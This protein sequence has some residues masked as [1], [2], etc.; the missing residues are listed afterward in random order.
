MLKPSPILLSDIFPHSP[1]FFFTLEFQLPYS[2]NM[3]DIF[4]DMISEGIV[5]VYMD[6]IFIFAPDEVTLTINT[7]QVLQ[8]LKDNDLFSNQ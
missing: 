1:H 8:Q 4:G 3:G 7:K 5:I 6:N 2:F